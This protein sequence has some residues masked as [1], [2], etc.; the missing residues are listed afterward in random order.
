ML[1]ASHAL[2][3]LAPRPGGRATSRLVAPRRDWLIDGELAVSA[4]SGCSLTPVISLRL[5]GNSSR[6][7]DLRR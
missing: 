2:A 4:P 1:A 3:F 7:A 6:G 5:V